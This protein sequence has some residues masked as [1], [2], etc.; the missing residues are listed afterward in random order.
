M[1]EY[2]NNVNAT[3]LLGP[4]CWDSK[5]K[6]KLLAHRNC[7]MGFL[8]VLSETYRD[9]KSLVLGVLLFFC[10]IQVPRADVLIW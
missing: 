1:Y 9:W 5:L 2:C 3:M 6:E 7:K 8:S 10:I 4:E